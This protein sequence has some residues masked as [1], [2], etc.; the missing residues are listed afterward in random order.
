MIEPRYSFAQLQNTSL[1]RVEIIGIIGGIIC[2]EINPPGI[3]F[4][5]APHGDDVINDVSLESRVTVYQKG[6]FTD[7]APRRLLR[8]KQ[9]GNRIRVVGSYTPQDR[10]YH[11]IDAQVVEIQDR[12]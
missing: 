6:N 12:L 3:S 11:R 4:T 8:A 1:P 5:L 7:D 9:L 10:G 2:D